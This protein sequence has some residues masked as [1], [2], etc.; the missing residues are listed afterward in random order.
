MVIKTP[1]LI[2]KYIDSTQFT[3]ILTRSFFCSVRR[4]GV[5]SNHPKAYTEGILVAI[6]ASRLR[7]LI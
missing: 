6:S 2:L 3:A 5:D 1:D 4:G 7:S